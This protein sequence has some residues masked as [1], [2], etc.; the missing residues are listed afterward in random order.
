VQVVEY[1]FLTSEVESGTTSSSW[2]LNGLNFDFKDGSLTL[3]NALD[4]N[5]VSNEKCKDSDLRLTEV[6]DINVL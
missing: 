6:N 4:Q 3:F 5:G 1:H 2:L